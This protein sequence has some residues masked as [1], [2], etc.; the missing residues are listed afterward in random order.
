MNYFE[1]LRDDILQLIPTKAASK[2]AWGTAENNN[3]NSNISILTV[4]SLLWL[5]LWLC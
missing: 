2:T 3:S 4:Q 5:L 1:S